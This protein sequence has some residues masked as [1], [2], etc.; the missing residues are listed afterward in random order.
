MDIVDK[1]GKSIA[2]P[3]D[4]LEFDQDGSVINKD[5]L[6]IINDFQKIKIYMKPSDHVLFY[7]HKLPCITSHRGSMWYMPENTL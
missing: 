5:E 1:I 6:H 7:E 3:L 2:M 4:P